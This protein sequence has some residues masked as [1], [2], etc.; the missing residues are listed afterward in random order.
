[1][2]TTTKEKMIVTFTGNKKEGFVVMTADSIE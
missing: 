2:K 1:M